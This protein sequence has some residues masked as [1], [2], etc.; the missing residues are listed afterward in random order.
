MPGPA[1][2]GEMGHGRASSATAIGDTASRLEAAC[3]DRAVSGGVRGGP[4]AAGFGEPGDAH[5]LAVRGRS[6]PL[7]VRA[8]APAADLPDPAGAGGPRTAPAATASAWPVRH[9]PEA[10]RLADGVLVAFSAARLRQRCTVL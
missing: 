7:R 10:H 6:T 5:E 3:K 4:A 9:D 2:L 8:V 1:I